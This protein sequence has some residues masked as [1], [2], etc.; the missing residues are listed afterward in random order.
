MTLH[1]ILVHV[2]AETHRHAGHADIV[3]ELVDGAAGLRADNSNL[4]DGDRAWW[5]SYRNRLESAA[6]E[7]AAR[8]RP[9]ARRELASGERDGVLPQPTASSGASQVWWSGTALAVGEQLAVVVEEDDA[10]AQ[11]APALLGVAADHGGEVTGLAGGVGAGSY[12]VA[13]RDHIRSVSRRGARSYLP[14]SSDYR[15]RQV[16]ASAEASRSEQVTRS[17]QGVGR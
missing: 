11:Q 13:H 17:P 6:K 15:I 9:E 10:V 7:A 3:R 8:P 12:V 16:C 14:C 4:P 5:E 1:R 2:I